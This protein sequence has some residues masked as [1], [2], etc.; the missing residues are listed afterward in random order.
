MT[1]CNVAVQELDA[2]WIVNWVEKPAR[3]ERYGVSL[4]RVAVST[5]RDEVDRRHAELG[6]GG[7]GKEVVQGVRMVDAAIGTIGRLLRS[8]KLTKQVSAKSFEWSG[9]RLPQMTQVAID[10]RG[11]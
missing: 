7:L 11:T 2:K 10:A 1:D 4:Q 8:A 6:V 9:F 5:C 3:L